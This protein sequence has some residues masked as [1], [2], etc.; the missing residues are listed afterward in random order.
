MWHELQVSLQRRTHK[1]L[2][3]KRYAN[4]QSTHNGQEILIVIYICWSNTWAVTAESD[5]FYIAY[6]DNWNMYVASMK[7]VRV[8]KNIDSKVN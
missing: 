3:T 7:E 4:A 6:G 8:S 5:R 2:Q 1:Q